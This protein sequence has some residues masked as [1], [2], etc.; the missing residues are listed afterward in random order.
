MEEVGGE[1]GRGT[2]R[3]VGQFCP[4]LS[5][6]SRCLAAVWQIS[7]GQIFPFISSESLANSNVTKAIKR[8]RKQLRSP[9]LVFADHK[10]QNKRKKKT[11]ITVIC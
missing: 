10:Q 8:S 4:S 3:E 5:K 1:G 6:A 9:V 11:F 7:S 2:S